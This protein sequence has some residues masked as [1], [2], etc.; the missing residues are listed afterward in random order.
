MIFRAERSLPHVHPFLSVVI[1][2]GVK[3]DLAKTGIIACSLALS[4]SGRGADDCPAST[5]RHSRSA[6]LP[7]LHALCS[8]SPVRVAARCW[9]C[10][11]HR[12]WAGN[13][14]AKLITEKYPA[15]LDIFYTAGQAGERCRRRSQHRALSSKRGS[16]IP[17]RRA[18]DAVA[19][20]RLVPGDWSSMGL[21]SPSRLSPCRRPPSAASHG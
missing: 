16:W 1:F 15:P 13:R 11:L 17:A 14:C 7:R 10:C 6:V 9:R 19:L 4:S 2:V 18:T 5:R 8:I 3:P 21:C 12:H 20:A